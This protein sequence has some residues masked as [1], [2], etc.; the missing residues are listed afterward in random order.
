MR[1]YSPRAR[2]YHRPSLFHEKVKLE[3]QGVMS[4]LQWLEFENT[5]QYPENFHELKK[6][7]GFYL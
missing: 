6:K 5:H 3:H 2:H 4:D 7:I 1:F